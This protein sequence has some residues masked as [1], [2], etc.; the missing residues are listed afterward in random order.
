MGSTYIFHFW[1][2]NYY[3][4]FLSIWE[5]ARCLFIWLNHFFDCF[6][7]LSWLDFAYFLI[8]SFLLD[9]HWLVAWCWA[10]FG[11]ESLVFLLL[12]Y[13]WDFGFPF[14]LMIFRG[15]FDLFWNCKLR[16]ICVC[17]LA[18]LFFLEML[19]RALMA[20]FAFL[21]KIDYRIF[22]SSSLFTE[23]QAHFDVKSHVQSLGLKP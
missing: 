4:S 19:F 11:L 22:Y 12:G 10:Y 20:F 18:N 8:F 15:V 9:A 13:R 7:N 6:S 1:V 21:F 5:F 17:C 2:L 14:I 23:F 3:V 16:A